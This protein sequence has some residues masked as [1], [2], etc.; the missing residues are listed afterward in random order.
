MCRPDGSWSL[1]A[2]RR[3]RPTGGRAARDEKGHLGLPLSCVPTAESTPSE[4]R[5]AL[6][7][8]DGS[9]TRGAVMAV[10]VQTEI[11]IARPRLHV[12]AYA[13]DPDNATAWYQ[14]IKAIEWK[15]PKP[16]AL[17]SKVGFVAQFLGRRLEYTYEIV[18]LIPGERLVQRTSEGPFPMGSHLHLARSRR[19][20][21]DDA[22]A[23]PRRRAGG[24]LEDRRS[25]DG[26]G[27]AKS[28][29]QR[30]SSAEGDLGRRV[31]RE[32]LIPG[33][34]HRHAASRSARGEDTAGSAPETGADGPIW[35]GEWKMA[36]WSA[37]ASFA[38][39]GGMLV[40]ALA[41]FSAVRS[42]NR[43]ARV[44]E[45]S[46][47]TAMRPL[48]IPSLASDPDYKVLW[49]DRHVAHVSGGRVIFEQ[50]DG[51][52]YLAMGLRNVGNGIVLLHGWYPR[53]DRA[54]SD[55]P[56]AEADDFR[57]LT[58][59]LYIPAG[60]TGYWEGAVREPDDPTRPLF[61]EAMR[62]RQPMRI[63]LLYGDQ[64]GG[65][66]TISRFTVLPASE[67]GWYAQ[68]SRHWNLD[69]PAPR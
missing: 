1:V 27:D 53:P 48:L 2:G 23:K 4:T 28:E 59:D 12:A 65:Q 58:I 13:S 52:I 68:V 49:A 8:G 43:S 64:Q 47:L 15:S 62:D 19:R 26:S 5:T 69:R 40:L 63:D 51:V 45:E 54:F 18:E 34:D 56:P 50:A 10:D 41:T 9:S 44:A 61:V 25:D 30:P 39:A 46:L 11:D 66:R 14:N 32:G 22:P 67:E 36:D 20:R 55:D 17:G 38:T 29:P 33:A 35:R 21:H 3:K 16:L 37:I 24:L 6:A 7:R 31:F 60:G 42:S 57:R